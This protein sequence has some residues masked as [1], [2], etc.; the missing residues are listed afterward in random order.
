[1]SAR[2]DFEQFGVG[3]VFSQ[4]GGQGVHGFD[5][6]VVKQSFAEV[7]QLLAVGWA[8]EHLVHP[9]AG[10]GIS[11]AGNVRRS[12]ISRD[13][14]TSLLP[15]PL[16]SSKMSWSIREPVST[17]AVA[18]M[19]TEPP[20]S[21]LRAMPRKRRGISSTPASSPPDMMRPVPE[22]LRLNARPMRVMDRPA[23]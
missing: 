20:F 17:S 4:G 8:P 9:C 1:M 13:R 16:N 12:A 14:M 11:I 18:I 21:I 15:V 6:P 10:A 5:R 7:G 19:V 3:G 23:Q 2:Q 22:P